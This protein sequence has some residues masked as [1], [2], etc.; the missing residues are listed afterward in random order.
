M[1]KRILTAPFTPRVPVA[2]TLEVYDW[3]SSTL[4]QG[5]YKFGSEVR[6]SVQYRRYVHDDKIASMI[7]KED[8]NDSVFI[9][10]V[11]TPEGNVEIISRRDFNTAI[12]ARAWCNSKLAALGY[13]VQVRTG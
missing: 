13:P 8:A 3:V 4:T 1:A 10:S 5:K 6:Y 7:W 9:A 2:R 11:T 12:V